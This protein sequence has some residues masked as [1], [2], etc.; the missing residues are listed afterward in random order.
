MF[1]SQVAFMI[2][3]VA[4]GIITFAI[5]IAFVRSTAL[6]AVKEHYKTRERA[7]LQRIKTRHS[8]IVQNH[9]R[10][11]ALLIYL[12]CGL[13]HP[14]HV[15]ESP[16]T[17][18]NS[19]TEPKPS[20]S[21]RR[22]QKHFAYEEKIEELNLEQRQEFRSQVSSLI[23]DSTTSTGYKTDPSHSAHSVSVVDHRNHRRY[24][25]LATG[26]SRFLKARGLDVLD[27]FLLLFRLHVDSRSGRL[28]S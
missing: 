3:F 28:Q 16:T 5:L 15:D 14:K 26:R 17:S 12:S 20:R 10:P 24:R 18:S 13:Y 25:N 2:A 21:E 6:E 27:R 7:A 9:S 4:L 19:S 11:T 22:K 8:I 1:L 23:L